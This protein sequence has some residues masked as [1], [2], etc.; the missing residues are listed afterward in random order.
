ME[1]EL[2]AIRLRYTEKIQYFERALVAMR[3][4]K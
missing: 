3:L 1:A 2:D 4:K